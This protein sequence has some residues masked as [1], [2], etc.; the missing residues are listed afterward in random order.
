[1]VEHEFLADRRVLIVRPTDSLTEADFETLSAEVD[2]HFEEEAGVVGL[3]IDAP[4]FPGWEDFT[5]FLAHVRFVR[6]HHRQL[7]RV[8]VVS[9]SRL[10]SLMPILGNMFVHAD[11]EKFPAG[12]V[13]EALTWIRAAN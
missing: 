7:Q 5:G 6:E 13:D 1:M 4:S 3:L 2:K 11:L 8:A 9:D 10:L 12:Q